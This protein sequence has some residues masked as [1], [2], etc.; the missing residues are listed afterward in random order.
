MKDAR[1]MKARIIRILFGLHRW[2]GV[3]LGALML[4][5][6]LSGFV[7]MYSPYPATSLDG[8]DYRMEGLAPLPSAD[9]FSLTATAV[10]SDAAIR[11]ARLEMMGDRPVAHLAWQ[12][13]QGVFSLT[14]S[15]LIDTVSESEALAVAQTYAARHGIAAEPEIK[16]LSERDEFMVAGYFNSARPFWQ[17]R[18]NDADQTML[19]V[20]SK[21]GEVR[22]RTTA[23]LRF[24]SWLGAIPHWLYFT[25][26]RK[27]AQ[28]WSDVIIWTSLGGC[29]LVVLGMFVGLRQLRR[30]NSTGRLDSPYRGAKFWHHMLGLVF[31]V[32]VL[33]W[34]FSGFASMQPW[35]WLETSDEAGDAASRLPGDAPSWAEI[36]PALT[37]QIAAASPD[38]LQVS[39]ATFDGRPYFIHALAS[40]ERV[41]FGADGAPAPFDT[42][43]QSRAAAILAGDRG[44]ADVSLMEK[45]DAYYYDGAAAG[46]LPV[47]KVVVPEM[48]DTAFY[49]D[50]VSGQ[51]RAIA[52]P[53][54]R[55]FRWLHL[56][57]HRM[58]FFDWMR[59]R[60][61]WDILVWTLML[62]VTA[63]CAFGVW[64]GA[65]KLLRGG[66]L[67]R[68]PKD[69]S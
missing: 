32:L 38:T 64:L 42:A 55:G 1:R 59:V 45:E 54:S 61:F 37:N 31:G 39:L 24:W 46:R 41:R 66:R 13:G 15:A 62:G 65:G 44:A 14:D 36:A 19:Y 26:L 3:V 8:R 16:G 50:P 57:L 69:N 67:D 28:L 4:M 58:D 10:P 63:V 29:F 20:S 49:L 5:W 11:A 47:V 12:D 40:G 6:C 33:T 68:R 34:T 17:V 51:V 30:R 43:S 60:P 52:D 56:G 9:A 48:E 2:T 7:M 53:G 25:E 18:L 21:T 35:G 27:D 23:S 22:Q